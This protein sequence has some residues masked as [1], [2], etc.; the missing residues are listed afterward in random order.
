MLEQAEPTRYW[1]SLSEVLSHLEALGVNATNL[2]LHESIHRLVLR[3]YRYVADDVIFMS[4][5]EMYAKA[6]LFSL[7]YAVHTINSPPNI[8]KKQNQGP[9]SLRFLRKQKIAGTKISMSFKHTLGA[10]QLLNS[11]YALKLKVP[12][13]VKKQLLVMN[14]RRNSLHF[15]TSSVISLESEYFNTV[16]WLVEVIENSRKSYRRK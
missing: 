11:A 4:A 7:G 9:I 2:D 12:E 14:S 1:K 10:T 8:R 6:R 5:F 15:R 3:S 13:D 16:G